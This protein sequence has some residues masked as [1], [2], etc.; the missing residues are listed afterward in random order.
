MDKKYIPTNI[1]ETYYADTSHSW[2]SA[3]GVVGFRDTF[4]LIARR[5]YFIAGFV[6]VAAALMGIVVLSMA[7]TYTAAATL[8]LERNNTQM[9][10]A[11]TQLDT[12]QRD[13]SAVETE[14]DIISSRVFAGRVVDATNLTEHPWFNT[15]LADEDEPG[16]LLGDL[17]AAA[18]KVVLETLGFGE[19]T[20]PRILPDKSVQRDRAISSLLAQMAVSRSGESFAVTVR[21]TSP[22]PELSATLANTVANLY[23]DWSRE[24]RRQ[25]MGD[26]VNFLRDRAN[27]VASRIAQNERVIT[28]FTRENHLAADERDDLVRHRIADLNT[29]LTSARVDLAGIRA[30]RE[31]GRRVIAGTAELEGSALDSPLLTTLRAEQAVLVRQRAQYASNFAAGHPQIVETDAQLASVSAMIGAEIRRIVEDLAGEEKVVNDRVLQLEA[32]LSDLQKTLDQ[33]SLAE[34]RLRELE[35]DLLAD[36]KLHDL[37]VARLGGLDP[38]AEVAKPSARVVSIAEVPTAPSF[39]QR[40]RIFAA[41]IAGSAVLAVILAV[42]LEASDM[43]IWSGHRITQ[44]VRLPNLANIPRTAQ[45]LFKSQANV[46]AR[47]TKKPRSA[48][49]EAYRSL[50]LACRAQLSLTKAV[51]VVTAPLSNHGTT[52]VAFGLAFSASRDGMRTLYVSLDGHSSD[53]GAAKR[54]EQKPETAVGSGDTDVLIRSVPDLPRLDIL[55]FPRP[56]VVHQIAA[57]ADTESAR[58]LFEKLR[59]AYDLVIVDTAPVL[60][61]EDANWLSPLVDGIVLVVRF[62]HTTE[63]ELAGAVS[64]LNLNHAPLIGTVLNGIDPRGR[65]TTEPLG[66]VNYPRQARTYFVS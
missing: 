6:A 13:R 22:D 66:P 29:Q 52:S 20:H 4:A 35:R 44:L 15:Y 7:D 63:S 49:T 18:R 34:I 65:P 60:L 61:V 21:L 1:E 43:R 59:A 40:G 3:V 16:T 11:V 33:R 64:R 57:V 23:V 54:H 41:G 62:G 58:Q 5:R 32:Q 36:Q 28:E 56:S 12:E 42:M 53:F 14:M 26:A 2:R 38:F 55:A 25:T 47:L 24:V 48:S 50:Y 39:P 9:L 27:Q 30:K 45:S 17:F 8:V 37:V 19:P 51:V 10:E 31:Q 46:V